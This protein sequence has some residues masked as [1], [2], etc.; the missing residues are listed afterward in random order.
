ML[1]IMLFIA[2][3]G[4]IDNVTYKEDAAIVLGAGIKGENVTL[5]LS[6]RLDKAVEYIGKNPS[7]II[8]VSGGQGFQEDISESL[9]M[10]RYLVDNGVPNDKIIK[11]Q[12]STSTY[13][14]C[15]FSKELLDKYFD[16]PYK[17]VIITNDF[18]IY[19]AIQISKAVGLES[20]HYHA[21]TEWYT[22]SLNYLRECVAVV[23]TWILGV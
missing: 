3:F 21:K 6:H 12:K 16:K 7:A 2:I 4:K 1:S 18:H 19:R 20:T 13:E 14:N 22:V 17:T 11:E 8:V 15:L 23:K 10:E 9:A 5:T